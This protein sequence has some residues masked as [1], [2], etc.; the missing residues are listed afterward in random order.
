VTTGIL[1]SKGARAACR[2]GLEAAADLAAIEVAYFTRDI[3]FSDHCQ[4]L[5]NE[6]SSS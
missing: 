4:A 1:L 3:R 2:D 5:K 6:F